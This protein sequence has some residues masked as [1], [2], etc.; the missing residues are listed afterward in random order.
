MLLAPILRTPI[1]TETLQTLLKDHHSSL[2]HHLLQWQEQQDVLLPDPSR[3][4]PATP[5]Q[6]QIHRDVQQGSAETI[7]EL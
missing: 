7:C 5:N 2:V 6:D 4:L 3:L 1:P